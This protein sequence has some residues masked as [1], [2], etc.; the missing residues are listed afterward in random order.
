MI[1]VCRRNFS[2]NKSSK[3]C[4]RQG[5]R[6]RINICLGSSGGLHDCDCGGGDR[7]GATAA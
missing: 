3:T 4:T 7:K 1:P 2:Q 5:R 6:R